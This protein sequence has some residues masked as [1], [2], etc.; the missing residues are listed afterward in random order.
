M[1]LT[2][3]N[4]MLFELSVECNGCSDSISAVCFC[5]CIEQSIWVCMELVS[6]AKLMYIV[7][8]SFRTLFVY[9]NVIVFTAVAIN[10]I[11]IEQYFH[12]RFVSAQISRHH[13]HMLNNTIIL[14]QDVNPHLTFLAFD[15]FL[16]PGLYKCSVV[17]D[18]TLNLRLFTSFFAISLPFLLQLTSL[19]FTAFFSYHW[20]EYL[21]R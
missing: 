13:W 19:I 15:F 21:K 8:V 2:I 3:S 10:L 1:Y 7:L 16:E 17:G 5:N 11:Y 6:A 9:I 20:E 18:L 14:E 4:S 12:F